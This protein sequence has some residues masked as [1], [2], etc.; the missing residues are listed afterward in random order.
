L[1]D[2]PQLKTLLPYVTTGGDVYRAQVIGYFD[3]K[4]P[5][6]REEVVIDATSSPARQVYWKDLKM[7]GAGYPAEVL[8][9]SQSDAATSAPGQ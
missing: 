2:L 6:T 4:G 7:L 5:A 3:D 1:V 8:G 9:G